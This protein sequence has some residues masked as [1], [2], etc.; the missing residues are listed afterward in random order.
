MM[1]QANTMYFGHEPW[2]TY[3]KVAGE[4]KVRLTWVFFSWLG[5]GLGLAWPSVRRLVEDEKFGKIEETRK[6][7]A[8]F[9]ILVYL[10][11]RQI[12][13]TSMSGCSYL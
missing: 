5:K 6:N 2:C 1:H 7:Y 3:L 13:L 8:S 11:W 12:S 9:E 10:I 4:L